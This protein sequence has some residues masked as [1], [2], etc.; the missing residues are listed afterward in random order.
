MNESTNKTLSG[1][2]VNVVHIHDNDVGH[3]D[4]L[5]ILNF[6]IWALTFGNSWR[7]FYLLDSRGRYE[8]R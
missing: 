4:M 8:V 2:W 3:E 6:L 1:V 5:R 7:C